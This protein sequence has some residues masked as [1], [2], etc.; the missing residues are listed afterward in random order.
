M[1]LKQNWPAGLLVV[2]TVVLLSDIG[3]LAMML[4]DPIW[5][6]GALVWTLGIW[7]ALFLGWLPL[8]GDRKRQRHSKPR[9]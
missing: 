2:W 4:V 5:G 9:S 1:V 6:L 3:L 7:M 8:P